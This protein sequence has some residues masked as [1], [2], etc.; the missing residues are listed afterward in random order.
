MF[1]SLCRSFSISVF[2]SSSASFF[3]ICVSQSFV[4]YSLHS[5]FFL[6][7]L[8]SVCRSFSIFLSIFFFHL[9]FS[10][11]IFSLF[12]L[13]IS[14]NFLLSN[15]VCIFLSF[16]KQS[17]FL[18]LEKSK[19]INV[20]HH[21]KYKL[22]ICIMFLLSYQHMFTIAMII[23]RWEIAFFD[24]NRFANINVLKFNSNLSSWWSVYSLL[25]C[26][27]TWRIGSELYLAS[28]RNTTLDF[29]QIAIRCYQRTHWARS[30][31]YFRKTFR[32]KP[33]DLDSSKISLMIFTF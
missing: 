29:R 32:G 16:I 14:S 4:H 12:S 33:K 5:L 10:F 2:L 15:Q 24:L 1:F 27:N 31:P 19:T 17:I 18:L 28:N 23:S 11:F 9:L 20:K 30:Y 13:F 25:L 3:L 6:L 21:W 26:D 22:R 7:F 8:S